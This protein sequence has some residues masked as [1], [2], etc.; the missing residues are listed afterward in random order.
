[1]NQTS[2]NDHAQ[3]EEPP[4]RFRERV[5]GILSLCFTSPTES[6]CLADLSCELDRNP[7]ALRQYDG[8]DVKSLRSYNHFNVFWCSVVHNYLTKQRQ[9]VNGDALPDLVTRMAPY[10][11]AMYVRLHPQNIRESQL[12][13]LLDL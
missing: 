3:I 8:V 13:E 10:C 2:S 11:K 4:E 9:L 1:M 5:F 6:G 12:D 7:D